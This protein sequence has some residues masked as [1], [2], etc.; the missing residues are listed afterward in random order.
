MDRTENEN[1]LRSRDGGKIRIVLAK[2]V[3]TS[4][5]FLIGF[6]FGLSAGCA[7]AQEPSDLQATPASAA[8]CLDDAVE[9]GERGRLGCAPTDRLLPCATF[10]RSVDPSCGAV[11]A[12]TCRNTLSSDTGD[13]FSTDRVREVLSHPELV[14]ALAESP[15][16]L[17]AD[18]R[19]MDGVLFRVEIAGRELLVGGACRR[20]GRG[21]RF[22]PTGVRAAVTFLREL[23]AHQLA[24][25]GCAS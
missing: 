23:S 12:N 17:G 2:G 15:V 9:W 5:S 13:P 11:S 8:V 25:P 6:V 7:R 1:R 10:E 3:H 16:L 14:R 20:P 4:R 24:Q 22:V 19:L 18:V 21:C